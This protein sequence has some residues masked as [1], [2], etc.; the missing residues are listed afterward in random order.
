MI[1]SLWMH[2]DAPATG[3]AIRHFPRHPGA[4]QPIVT[5]AC[6]IGLVVVLAV[7][8]F[9]VIVLSGLSAGAAGGCGGG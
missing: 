1:A 9:I 6:I 2:L 5:L 7:V 4:R 8:S 3:V